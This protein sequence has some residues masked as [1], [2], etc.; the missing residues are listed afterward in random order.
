MKQIGESVNH[1]PELAEAVNMYFSQAQLPPLV[2]GT[3]G[4][5]RSSLSSLSS[6]RSGVFTSRSMASSRGGAT[7]VQVGADLPMS[8]S[9]SQGS[10]RSAR[11]SQGSQSGRR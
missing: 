6:G 7:P 9:S 1:F 4:S 10:F 5:S 3:P 8:P 2:G 11:S